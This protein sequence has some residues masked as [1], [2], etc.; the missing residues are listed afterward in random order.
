MLPD[1][2]RARGKLQAKGLRHSNYRLSGVP[3]KLAGRAIY[4]FGELLL[5]VHRRSG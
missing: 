3:S 2:L 4:G 5:P 1:D